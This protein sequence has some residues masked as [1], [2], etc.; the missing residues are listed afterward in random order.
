MYVMQFTDPSGM[1]DSGM[2][3]DPADGMQSSPYVVYA[4]KDLELT[5]SG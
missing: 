4:L 3:I 1:R 2:D 5:M